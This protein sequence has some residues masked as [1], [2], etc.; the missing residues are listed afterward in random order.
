[1][2]GKVAA[3]LAAGVPVVGSSLALEG[4][5]LAAEEGAV[6][7]DDARALAREIVR[8]YRD[9]ALWSRLSRAGYERAERDYSFAART[10][11]VAAAAARLHVVTRRV[12]ECL[13][14]A[15][16]RPAP[17]DVPGLEVD[18]C[19]G[20]AEYLAL[21]EGARLR[22]R[23]AFEE[24]LIRDADGDEVT[25]RGYSFPAGRPVVYHAA[26][27]LG[28]G[29]NRRVGWREELACPVTGL[30]NRQRATAAFAQ[31]ILEDREHAATDVYLTEQVTPLFK[32]MTDRFRTGRITGSEYLGPQAR[33]G[34]VREGIRHEDLERL[35]LADASQ[36]LVLSCDVLEHVNEPRAALG[37]LARV[38]RPGG[39]LLFTVPFVWNWD[40]N[41][42]RA[43]IAGD[44][45]EHLV[46]PCYHGNPLDPNGSLAFF[47]Y[48]WELLDWVRA[49]GFSDVSVVCYWSAALGHLGGMLEMF[50]AVR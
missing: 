18:V 16:D 35:S 1:V 3:S 11:H 6:A 50:H 22:E 25:Y 34:E 30:N 42:R 46:D 26:V 39:H 15:P 2:K 47:D 38:L 5:G 33:G 27:T 24:A 20:K 23:V 48:G 37:E 31:R 49:A 40:E 12:E 17:F 28:P 9:P 19:R 8:V 36:D 7:A 21:R 41:R 14:T 32:W 45:V 43:R 29:G 4:M 13:G 44:T 10:R